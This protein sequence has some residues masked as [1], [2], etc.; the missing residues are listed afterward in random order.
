MPDLP[1][2]LELDEIDADPANVVRASGHVLACFDH[3]TQDSG[4]VS[5]IVRT[6]RG[7]LFVKTAGTSAP[8]PAG[9]PVPYF[10]HAGRV[11]LLRNAVEV[12]RTASHAA[13]ARLRNVVESP[14]GPVLVYDRAP[15]EL[16]H[17]RSARRS[18]PGTPYQ[19][20]GDCPADTQLAIFDQLLD[21]HVRLEAAGWV[22]SD[23]YDG[24]LMVDAA[25]S[26]LALVDLD[27]YRRGPSV[28]DMGRMFGSSLF[29]APEEL[30]L[31]APIDSRTTA[32]TL[33]RLIRH[34]GTRLTE[35]LT[36]FSGGRTLAGVVERATCPDRERR[37][38]TVAELAS[39]W[40]NGRCAD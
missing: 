36:A 25:A 8:P 10:D 2:L 1:D 26:R 27:T 38:G 11:A 16:I 32:F 20:F 14:T 34:F 40:Q 3:R 23:L 5:W 29:M 35:D 31:G 17:V 13:L 9:A 7:D 37:Y 22:A 6:A 4:N 18:E 30:E 28:N 19:R 15:G 39:A 33:G 24:C 21:A 12:A